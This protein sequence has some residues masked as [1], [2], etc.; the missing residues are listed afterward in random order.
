MDREQLRTIDGKWDWERVFAEVPEPMGGRMQ[1]LRDQ[2]IPFCDFYR[3]RRAR[4]IRG[5]G[6]L[7]RGSPVK[8]QTHNVAPELGTVKVKIGGAELTC[9]AEMLPELVK[10][11]LSRTAGIAVMVIM[12]LAAPVIASADKLVC[13]GDS[14]TA[15]YG[16]PEGQSYCDRFGG[17]DA[18]VG[19]DTTRTGRLRFQRDV[20]ARRPDV[21]T[22]AFGL[23][24]SY[25]DARNV[26]LSEYRANIRYFVETLK[27]R[28]IRPILV[29]PNVTMRYWANISVWPYV[30]ELRSVAHNQKVD[31]VDAYREFAETVVTGIGY[32]QLLMDEVHPNVVGH[33]IIAALLA[34]KL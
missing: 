16:V 10:A 23:G 26:P 14:V 7:S 25:F 17:I 22:I 8:K 29:T 4:G 5:R 12:L 34:K 21:V 18:G 1:W 32:N 33:D 31:L 13:F 20:L 6:R 11:I 27:D 3:E 19:G 2:G 28:G 30:Q 24:D 15:G 9:S